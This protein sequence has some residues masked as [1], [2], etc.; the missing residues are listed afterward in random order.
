[1]SE[2]LEAKTTTDETALR[3]AGTRGETGLRT[4]GQRKINLLWEVTQAI[5]ALSVTGAT[6]YAALTGRDSR[7]LENAFVL[8]IGIYFVRMNHTKTG[9]VQVDDSGR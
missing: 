5:I 6:I 7:M 8:I 4:A 1:M 2:P 3:E 9:G